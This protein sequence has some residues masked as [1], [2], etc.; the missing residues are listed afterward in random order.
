MSDPRPASSA[1]LRDLLRGGAV[2]A[3]G[4]VFSQ[5]GAEQKRLLRNETNLPAELFRIEIAQIDAVE[6]HGAARSDRSVRG[7]RFTSV[8]LPL[9][10]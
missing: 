3:P 2:H 5:C 7:I 1:A 9:P 6:Q 10:V 8:L 4:N